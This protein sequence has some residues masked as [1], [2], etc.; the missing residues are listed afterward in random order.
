MCIKA[1]RTERKAFSKQEKQNIL[2]KT[3]SRCGHCGKILT[4]DTM[5]IEHIFPLYKGGNHDEFN[6]VAL[7]EDCNNNKSNLVYEIT[8]YYKYILNEY[9]SEYIRKLTDLRLQN[10]QNNRLLDVDV[11]AYDLVPNQYKFTAYNMIKRKTKREKVLA[12]LDRVTIKLKLEKAY[13]GDTDEIYKLIEQ[14][15]QKDNDDILLYDSEYDVLNAIKTDEVYVLRSKD[16]IYGAFIFKKI[17]SD[18]ERIELL[19]L[20]TI[21]ENSC[22]KQKYITTLAIVAPY[23]A[24]LYDEIM[25]T[26]SYSLIKECAIPMFFNKT[27]NKFNKQSKSHIVEIPYSIDGQDGLLSFLTIRGLKNQLRVNWE[28]Y[29]DEGLL[30]DE[31]VDNWIEETFSNRD[32]LTDIETE[33]ERQDLNRKLIDKIKENKEKQEKG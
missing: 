12:F 30:T 3:E 1:N 18:N 7:C 16:K 32:G 10:K 21:E 23:A 20:N 13:E 5:T 28:A 22:L 14:L 6:L 33:F 11:K 2:S 15:K 4:V 26:F 29:I 31:D 19:Q 8:D 25:C 24:E 27:G 17:K 9:V